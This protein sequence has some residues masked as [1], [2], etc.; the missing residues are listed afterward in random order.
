[1][2][3]IKFSVNF[4]SSIHQSSS[5]FN[6]SGIKIDYLIFKID[7][8]SI[9][10]FTLLI[11]GSKKNYESSCENIGFGIFSKFFYYYL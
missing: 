1:M 8:K 5:I 10:V 7:D 3:I 11:I 6:K 2:P 9:I 4:L